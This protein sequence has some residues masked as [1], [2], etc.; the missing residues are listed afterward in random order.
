MFRPVPKLK[1]AKKRSR[2]SLVKEL[3][4][5]FSIFIRNR[6]GNRCVQCGSM[7]KLTNGHLFSR[8]NHSTRWDEL[9]CAC[10]CSG[11]NMRHEYEF[12]PFRRI[13]EARI[14]KKKYNDLW[15][16]HNQTKIFKDYELEEKIEH[17]K[18]LI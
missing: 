5:V 14:G 16:R 2:K 18:N 7:E 10:Q 12:E 17:Y 9:N 13:M 8:V 6:D 15:F 3:D 1:K 11:C 4:R